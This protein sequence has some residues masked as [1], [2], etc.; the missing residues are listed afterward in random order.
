MTQDDSEPRDDELEPLASDVVYEIGMFQHTGRRIATSN[1]AD[2]DAFRESMLIH[3]RC[4]MDFFGC[5]PR[6]G[7]VFLS[8]KPS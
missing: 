5:E 1:G 6:K 3:A 2:Q 7:A 4:L 8:R